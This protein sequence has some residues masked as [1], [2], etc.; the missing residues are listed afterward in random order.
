MRSTLRYAEQYKSGNFFTHLLKHL[1]LSISEGN[2]KQSLHILLYKI[3]IYFIIR[4]LEGRS[5]S[6]TTSGHVRDLSQTGS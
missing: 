3:K 4:R 5:N 2:V 1:M 6:P